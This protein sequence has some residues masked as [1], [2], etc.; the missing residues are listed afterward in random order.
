ME[1]QLDKDA[2]EGTIQPP[3][4]EYHSKCTLKQGKMQMGTVS[5]IEPRQFNSR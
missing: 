4:L 5:R 2:K 1:R 3:E